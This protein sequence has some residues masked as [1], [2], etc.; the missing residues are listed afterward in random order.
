MSGYVNDKGMGI[1]CKAMEAGEEAKG[2]GVLVKG[3]LMC[4]NCHVVENGQIRGQ[5]KS[6]PYTVACTVQYPGY[7]RLG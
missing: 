2:Q 3:M 6:I 1:D 4:R 7:P 5:H